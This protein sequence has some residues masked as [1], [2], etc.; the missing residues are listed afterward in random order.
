[1]PELKF[2]LHGISLKFY[3]PSLV[4]ITGADCDISIDTKL[5]KKPSYECPS[6][7]SPIKQF[8]NKECYETI[9]VPSGAILTVKLNGTIGSRAY[10]AIAGGIQTHNFLGSKSTFPTGKLGGLTGGPLV[11]GEVIPL[12]RISHQ[13]PE[14]RLDWPIS[15]RPKLSNHWEIKAIGGPYGAPDYFH[16][17][18]IKTLWT[19]FYTVSHNA[20]RL[21]IRLSGFIPKWARKDGGLGG[22]FLIFS[23]LSLIGGLYFY[24]YALE[25]KGKS[26]GEISQAYERFG[27]PFKS[28]DEINQPLTTV[29][30]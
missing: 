13:L 3:C 18:D 21:G 15:S 20:N 26:K 9:P 8:K 1:M 19:N 5:Q 30:I 7:G 28:T 10:L 11:S 29:K 16:P 23:I 17:D 2:K 6:V 27:G 22:V 25:T 14:L 24:K 12:A 4:A